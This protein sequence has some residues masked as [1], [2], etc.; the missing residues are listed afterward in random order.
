MHAWAAIALELGC[1]AVQALQ[2][3]LHLSISQV[4]ALYAC[5]LQD[6]ERRWATRDWIAKTI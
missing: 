5:A 4:Y 6:G 1:E 3:S 2:V